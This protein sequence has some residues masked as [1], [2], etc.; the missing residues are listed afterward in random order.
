[1]NYR[2]GVCQYKHINDFSFCKSYSIEASS[3]PNSNIKSKLK[4]AF[5][6]TE[7]K[8]TDW[9]KNK[10]KRKPNVKASKD[11]SKLDTSDE[12]EDYDFEIL[13]HRDLQQVKS[14]LESIDFYELLITC[15]NSPEPVM[16]LQLE[17]IRWHTPVL[18]VFA[19]FYQQHDKIRL[20][21]KLFSRIFQ[22]ETIIIISL[23]KLR[24]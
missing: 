9:F 20:R 2:N 17:S 21:I 23:L 14:H 4:K 5:K 24:S 11:E 10:S 3:Y 12:N 13:E 18:S 22:F 7:S 8:F 15:Q 16:Q 19:T 1:M 6:K